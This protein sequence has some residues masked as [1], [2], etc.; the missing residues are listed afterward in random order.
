MGGAFLYKAVTLW[1]QG[2]TVIQVYGK[3]LQKPFCLSQLHNPSTFLPSHKPKGGLV[4][5]AS[6]SLLSTCQT[7]AM[8]KDRPGSEL[9]LPGR[10]PRWKKAASRD[11]DSGRPLHP[12][13]H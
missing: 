8:D 1:G 10:E 12:N 5:N 11:K 13:P 7:K 9:R 4:Q 3:P 6:A 2:A